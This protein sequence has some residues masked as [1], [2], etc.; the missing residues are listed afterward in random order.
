MAAT[1]DEIGKWFDEAVARGATHMVVVCD[2]FDYE[3]YPVPVMPGED[4][5]Q[6]A[7]EYDGKSMQRVME[8]YCLSMNRNAQLGEHRAFHYQA[9]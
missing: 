4:P 6:I 9:A 5:R 2:D 3:D 1:R 7:A 8:V